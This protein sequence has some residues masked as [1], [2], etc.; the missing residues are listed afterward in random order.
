VAGAFHALVVVGCVPLMGLLL[1]P[2]V[3]E[4]RG[5]LLAD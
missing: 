1:L 5:R 4:T 2:L 3:L